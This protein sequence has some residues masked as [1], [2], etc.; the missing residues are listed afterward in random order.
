MKWHEDNKPLAMDILAKRYF[1]MMEL[2]KYD[3]IVPPKRLMLS[4][5]IKM[6]IDYKFPRIGKGAQQVYKNALQLL[7]TNDFPIDSPEVAKMI[8]SNYNACYGRYSNAYLNTNG[9]IIKTIFAYLQN[10]DLI[11]ENTLKG[12]DV[13]KKQVAVRYIVTAADIEKFK[14]GF[15][16]KI[17]NSEKNRIIN[18]EFIDLIDFIVHYGLRIAECLSL[19]WDAPN[20]PT[21]PY[22]NMLRKSV[23][24]DDRIIIDGKRKSHKI[25]KVREF[26]I[27]IIPGGRDIINRLLENKDRNNGKV[28]S[29]AKINVVVCQLNSLSMKLGMP[30][31]SGAHSMRRYAVNYWEKELNIPPHI[32]AYL[33]GH[34]LRV[35]QS[36]YS[37]M[38][39]AEDLISMLKK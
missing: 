13:E 19:Y 4:D 15:R 5:G 8:I 24:T 20:A 37:K 18:Q 30:K 1:A 10:N 36:N 32:C 12:L 31:Y 23:I 34:E 26:P 7:V 29:W 39:S 28:F 2:T 35:R 27:D 14:A 9:N 17:K 21:I 38:P 3:E 33:A 6:F 11:K 16:E 25:P 22:D